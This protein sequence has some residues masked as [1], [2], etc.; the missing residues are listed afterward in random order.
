[1]K[2]KK[3]ELYLNGKLI[4]SVDKETMTVTIN[5]KKYLPGN[6]SIKV[7]S[8][9][10]EGIKGI[11]Y[12][13]VIIASDINPEKTGYQVI[14]TLNH[15]VKNFTEGFEFYGDKLFEST[16]NHGESY[17]Y[18]YNPS[19]G[20]EITSLKL[21]NEYFGEGIT[22]LNDK[23]YQLT[24]KSKKGFVYDVNTFK[25]LKEFTFSSEEGWGMTN[26]GKNIIMS[27]GTSKIHFI[28]P[29]T[30]ERIKSI[31]VCDNKGI[32]SN[33]NELEYV[34]GVIYAN[35]WMT[36]TILKIDAQNGRVLKIINMSGI[37]SQFDQNKIDVLNGIAFNKKENIFYVT[38][39][40]W[41][42]TFK[43]IFK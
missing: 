3:M 25:K 41:P 2:I 5:S 8:T 14:G 34:D 7:E 27:D 43:V 21:D 23:I 10:S 16:G 9:N 26:D 40:Y 38:G 28:N 36:Q 37:Q 33:I 30:F 29:D 35:I 24:Y 11:N 17:I 31:E 42:K 12:S 22:I 39:K 15:S 20:K 4:N 1:M 32:I 13:N 18:S 6:T 19:T